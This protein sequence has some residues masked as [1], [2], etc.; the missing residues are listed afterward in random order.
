MKNLAMIKIPNEIENIQE[1]FAK[2]ISRPLTESGTINPISSCGRFI[3]EEA[4]QFI[5][6]SF[7]LMSHKRLEIYNQQFWYRLL[8]MMQ[9]NFP[10]TF[11]LLG[12]QKF[13][14]ITAEYLVDNPPK[15]WSL[16]TLGE[17]FPNWIKH[18]N[19]DT[20]IEHSVEI[21]AICY[22]SSLSLNQPTISLAASTNQDLNI[23]L[24]TQLFLQPH[25]FL[26]NYPYDLF[27]FREEILKRDP[28]Y[29]RKNTLP[30]SPEITTQYFVVFRTRKNI[31]AWQNISRAE[32]QLLQHF[33]NGCTILKVC[34]WIEQQDTSIRASMTENIQKFVQEW[35]QLE[36]LTLNN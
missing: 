10:L 9:T 25:L 36:W 21:D 23:L 27:K 33:K 28:E 24:T 32:S 4:Q 15:H 35:I 1:W 5:T 31:T 29:W 8:N 6:G 12:Y 7:N 17:H 18:K 30:I 22:A 14:K 20:L 19:Y 26:V 34:E 16:T 13:R 3:E 11:R 2:V